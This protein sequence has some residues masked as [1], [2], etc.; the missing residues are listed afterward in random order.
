MRPSVVWVGSAEP[1]FQKRIKAATERVSFDSDV[2]MEW[3]REVYRISR[4]YGH[5][6]AVQRLQDLRGTV[7]DSTGKSI[8]VWEWFSWNFG[9]Q[10]FRAAGKQLCPLLKT[11]DVTF[12]LYE[13]NIVGEFKRMKVAG[14]NQVTP[15]RYSPLGKSYL[16][17][18]RRV[19]LSFSDHFYDHL[20]E[21]LLCDC[22]KYYGHGEV[23]SLLHDSQ[24]IAPCQIM[25]EERRRPVPAAALFKPIALGGPQSFPIDMFVVTAIKQYGCEIGYD[26][27][28]LYIRV[29]YCPLVFRDGLAIAKT[30]LCPGY[31][32]TPEA[33]L[34]DKQSIPSH[35]RDRAKKVGKSRSPF[36]GLLHSNPD[37]LAWFHVN[38]YPQV[39]LGSDPCLVH[40][41]AS[42]S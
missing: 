30:F 36:Q 16:V 41:T 2:F 32:A 29:G 4:R 17:Q 20:H 12:G 10:V 14:K 7:V 25:D 9:H 37:L 31:G 40:A 24:P 5:E 21:R 35:I 26:G 34:Y 27:S 13:H 8:P 23:F 11:N 1:E 38:G 15:I 28:G 18:G 33:G 39:V 19:T 6:A 22:T 3:E 42:P